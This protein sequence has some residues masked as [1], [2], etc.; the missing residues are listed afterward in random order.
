MSNPDQVELDAIRA[1]ADGIAAACRRIDDRLGQ[2]G[3]V[4]PTTL[5]PGGGVDLTHVSTE[6]SVLRTLSGTVKELDTLA[7]TM[8][9]RIQDTLDEQ[10]TGVIDGQVVVTWKRNEKTPYFN[11]KALE[12][13]HPEIA[14]AYTELREGNRPFKVVHQ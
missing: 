12:K 6:L 9:A 8:R 2:R 4:A 1:L 7:K 5:L 10:D 11:K 13:D 3:E 14:A